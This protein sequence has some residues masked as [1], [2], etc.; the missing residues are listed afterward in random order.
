MTIDRVTRPHLP[1]NVAQGQIWKLAALVNRF[2][3]QIPSGVDVVVGVPGEGLVVATLVALH[4]NCRLASLA[5]LLEG[6]T[7]ATGQTRQPKRLHK[8]PGAERTCLVVDDY[9]G[10]GARLQAARSQINASGVSG[11]FI[12]LA[13][14]G[15]PNATG[16]DIVLSPAQYEPVEQ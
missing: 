11:Q 2:G 1:D 6:S 10:T 13:L 15:D 8:E 7:I 12:Y 16:A 4:L 3:A 5:H 14:R 9:L